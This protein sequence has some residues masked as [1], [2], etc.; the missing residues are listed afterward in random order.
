LNI[1]VVIRRYEVILIGMVMLLSGAVMPSSWEPPFRSYPPPHVEP[2]PKHPWI[3]LTFD[4]GPHPRTEDLLAVLRQ[5]PVSATFFV[6]GKMAD[7]YPQIIRDIAKDGHQLANHTYTH[8]NMSQLPSDEVISELEQT[9]AVVQRLTG[10]DA[11]LFRPPGGGFSRRTVRLTAQAGYRMVLWSV[12]TDDVEGASP[13][14]IR[15]RILKGAEDGGIVLMHSGIKTTV[16]VLPGVIAQLRE[17]G[18]NFVTVSTLLGLPRTRPA[19][20]SDTPLVQ[21][22][23]IK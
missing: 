1:R 23:S 22:A 14:F 7:R 18:Y 4:D 6:V 9:R 3:A 11:Y 16:D 17:R 19:L 8:R 5:A 2:A 12:L 20:P 21:T 10:Q 15:Q 13:K